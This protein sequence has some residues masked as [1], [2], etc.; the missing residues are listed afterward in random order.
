MASIHE[1]PLSRT[2]LKNTKRAFPQ[3]SKDGSML[4]MATVAFMKNVPP[5]YCETPWSGFNERRYTLDEWVIKPN[6]VH[7]LLQLKPGEHLPDVLH[8]LKSFTA[9]EINKLLNTR[10]R[11]C[12]QSPMTESFAVKLN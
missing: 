2:E 7:L 4:A 3:N 1:E 10:G 12:N 5:G 6:H 11:L 9:K 8:S